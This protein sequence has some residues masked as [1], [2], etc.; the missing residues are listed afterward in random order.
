MAK[1]LLSIAWETGVR[2]PNGISQ[3]PVNPSADR[4]AGMAWGA[5]AESEP[6]ICFAGEEAGHARFAFA[7]FAAM[8]V[9]AH[10]IA[11]ERGQALLLPD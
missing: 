10:F 9:C 11:T 1:Q 8:P 6:Q 5:A 7:R 4:A 2:Y 3:P